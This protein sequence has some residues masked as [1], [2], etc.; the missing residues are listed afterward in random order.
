MEDIAAFY[1]LP[2]REPH[3]GTLELTREEIIFFAFGR[4][5]V[6]VFEIPSSLVL[7]TFDTPHINTFIKDVRDTIR[8][9]GHTDRCLFEI[10]EKARFY[11]QTI[12]FC[13]NKE[14]AMAELKE[15]RAYFFYEV[16]R[17]IGHKK[18]AFVRQVR[19]SYSPVKMVQYRPPF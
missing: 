3:A 4:S 16:L 12:G 2:A 8:H 5:H 14:Q 17:Q 6:P 18:D 9:Y 1:A 10:R 19:S 7:R 13:E 15:A 11:E